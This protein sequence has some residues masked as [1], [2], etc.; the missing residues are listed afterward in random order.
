MRRTRVASSVIAAVGYDPR[1]GILEVEFRTGKIYNYFKVPGP[2]YEQLVKAKSMG[3][4]FNEVIRPN[5]RS[6]LVRDV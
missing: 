6:L 1:R 2:V 3:R 4:F 5:H